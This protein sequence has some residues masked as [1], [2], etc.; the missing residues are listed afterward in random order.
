[1]PAPNQMAFAAFRRQTVPISGRRQP[2]YHKDRPQVCRGY[3]YLYAE[4][5]RSGTLAMLDRIGKCSIVFN[6]RQPLK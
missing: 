5:F 4:G 3:P 1:M 2:L 6:V